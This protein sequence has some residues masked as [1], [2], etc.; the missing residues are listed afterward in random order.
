[1]LIYS[2]ICLFHGVLFLVSVP[3]LKQYVF[4]ITNNFHLDTNYDLYD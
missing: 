3:Q 4:Q 2:S 1:M